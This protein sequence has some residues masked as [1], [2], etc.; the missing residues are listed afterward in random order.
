MKE[1][2]KNSTQSNTNKG[3]R[4]LSLPCQMSFLVC[5]SVSQSFRPAEFILLSCLVATFTGP[6][7]VAN[8]LHQ[9]KRKENPKLTP[10]RPIRAEQMKPGDYVL[11][12]KTKRMGTSTTI[13]VM[14][15]V[16]AFD[17]NNKLKGKKKKQPHLME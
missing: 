1:N 16:I 3:S 6:G 4:S 11:I 14:T 8:A 15:S 10:I 13:C 12:I 9:M 5:L 17:H 2:R 7:F